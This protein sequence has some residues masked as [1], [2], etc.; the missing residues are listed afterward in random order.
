MPVVLRCP[1]VEKLPGGCRIRLEQ[2][3][4][5]CQHFGNEVAVTDQE[6]YDKDTSYWKENRVDVLSPEEQR[7]IVVQ[8]SIRDAHNRVEYLDSVDSVFNKVTFLK[9]LWWGIDHRNRA[10]KTQWTLNSIAGTIEPIYIAG[11]RISPSIYFFKK[12]D[13][14]KTLDT[15]TDISMGILNKDIK[16]STW[17]AYRYNPFRFGTVSAGFYHEFDVIR[18]FDAITQ[19]YKRENFIEVTEL[20]LG[21]HIEVTNGLYFNSDFSFTE[22]R[23]LEGYDF[24]ELVDSVLPNN[25][26]L[27]FE[28]YQALISKFTLTYIPGQKYMREPHR[29]VILGSKWPTFY[30]YYEKGISGLFGSDV[31]HDYLAGGIQQTFKIG[32]IGTSSYHIKGGAF[33]N[34]IN[35]RD[36]DQKFHRR[37]DP[38]WFSNPLHSFQGLDTL[39]PTQRMYLEAHFVHHDNGSI[40]NKIPFMK[41]TRIGLVFGAGALYVPEF[42]WQHY[43]I[44]AGLERTFKFSKRRLRIGAYAVLSDGNKIAPTPAWKVSFALMDT[45]N[46]KWNF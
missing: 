25:D 36:A 5:P 1:G 21:H 35:L 2:T 23:S 45:R 10:K 8:D 26:P 14:E 40:I 28:T 13:N 30:L 38:I 46:L 24:I 9:V 44:F 43:E 37:S 20:N 42:E 4:A 29:K 12:W 41:K 27:E 16:G 39:L 3:L 18:G 15:Y 33:I 34:N 6:A 19:I 32:T 31:N 17:W 7:Y 22:R 11:P